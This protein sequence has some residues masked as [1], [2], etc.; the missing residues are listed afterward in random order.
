MLVLGEK[1]G[2][3]E[4]VKHFGI[5]VCGETCTQLLDLVIGFDLNLWV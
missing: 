3:E 1:E 5:G 2:K 4:S